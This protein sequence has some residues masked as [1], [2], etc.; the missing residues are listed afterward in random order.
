MHTTYVYRC[1]FLTQLAD[2]M[3]KCE[4]RPPVQQ[5][6]VGEEIHGSKVTVIQT[7]P[8]ATLCQ[9][10]IHSRVNAATAPPQQHSQLVAAMAEH[11][12]IFHSSGAS[13]KYGIHSNKKVLHFVNIS[14]AELVVT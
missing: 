11:S 3:A 13:P 5:N 4:A 8:S 14:A 1:W 7:G 2:T 12:C 9:T 10:L 6:E